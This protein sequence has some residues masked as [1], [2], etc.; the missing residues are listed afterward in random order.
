[1][2]DTPKHTSISHLCSAACRRLMT[3]YP[4]ISRTAASAFR[5]ALTCGSASITGDTNQSTL[6]DCNVFSVPCCLSPVSLVDGGS[7]SASSLSTSSRS[8]ATSSSL[9]HRKLPRMLPHLSHTIKRS[10]CVCLSSATLNSSLA[11][12]RI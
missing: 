9:F 8:S 5:E 2:T 3:T 4:A 10:V 6:L 1:M 11:T 7:V 12:R